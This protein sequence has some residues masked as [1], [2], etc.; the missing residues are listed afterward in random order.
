M[1]SPEYGARKDVSG[2]RASSYALAVWVVLTLFFA[3]INHTVFKDGF[4][5]KILLYLGEKALLVFHGRP[6]RLENLGFV[7]PPLPYLFE[8]IFRNPFWASSIVGA[9]GAT[10][11]LWVVCMAYRKGKIS[12]PLLVIIVIFVLFCP[13]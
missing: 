13:I 3:A 5:S 11:F 8:L 1:G 6:P 9:F 10:C 2:Y 7:Y 12:K 4:A